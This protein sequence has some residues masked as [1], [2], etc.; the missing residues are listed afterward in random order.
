MRGNI[1]SR[2][3]TRA[4]E[5]GGV[6]E[7]QRKAGG[8]GNRGRHDKGD[9]GQHDAWQRTSSGETCEKKSSQ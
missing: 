5:G 7:S 3:W 8:E 9:E 4:R 2:P 1:A 6:V